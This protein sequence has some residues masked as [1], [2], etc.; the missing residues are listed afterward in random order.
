MSLEVIDEG[1]FW[2]AICDG[3]HKWIWAVIE[4]LLIQNRKLLVGYPEGITP[5]D[6]RML[7]KSTAK[8]AETMSLIAKAMGAYPDSNLVSLASTLKQRDERCTQVQRENRKLKKETK[9]LKARY[10]EQE[11]LT[12]SYIKRMHE[13]EEESEQSIELYLELKERISEALKFAAGRWSE[14]GDRAM[15]VWNILD[16]EETPK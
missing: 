8:M 7:K 11:R 10:E 6:V 16:P 1:E 3:D 2:Q 13:A 5:D 14:W 12:L 9:N 15:E 4:D